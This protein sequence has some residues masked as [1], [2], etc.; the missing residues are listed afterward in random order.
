MNELEKQFAATTELLHKNQQ[1]L[2]LLTAKMLE[3]IPAQSRLLHKII[4]DIAY[5]AGE[6]RSG[7]SREEILAWADE[8]D[9]MMVGKNLPSEEF[10][11]IVTEFALERIRAKAGIEPLEDAAQKLVAMD[12]LGD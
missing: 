11:R 4:A 5:T 3:M 7:A 6:C 9:R 2:E 12:Q 1:K 10:D 8:C